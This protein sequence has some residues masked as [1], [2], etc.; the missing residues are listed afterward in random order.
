MDKEN[1]YFL[2]YITKTHGLKGDLTVFLDVDDIQNYKKLESV[3]IEIGDDLIPFFIETIE[4]KPPD[5]A[6]VRFQDIKPGDANMLLKRNLYLPLDRLPKLSGNR[7]YFHEVIGFEVIDTKHGNTGKIE[8]VLEIEPQALFQISFKGKE[9][10]IPVV[11]EII[12]EVDREKKQIIVTTP[13]G[14]I[15]FYLE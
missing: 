3:F 14:L 10:L 12:N 11:D 4:L 6:I 15:E 2:G 13:E 1:F 7:F 8:S 9:I 5:K